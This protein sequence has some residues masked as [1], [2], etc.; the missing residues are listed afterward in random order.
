MVG[1]GNH[2]KGHRLIYEHESVHWSKTR[3]LDE[4]SEE[5]DLETAP[6]EG[7]DEAE[8]AQDDLARVVEESELV[9]IPEVKC[10]KS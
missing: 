1:S 4:E 3:S 6:D 5:H 2:T 9:L 8:D 7:E 10:S